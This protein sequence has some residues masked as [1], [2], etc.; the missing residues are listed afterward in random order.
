MLEI[1]LKKYKA[2]L[3]DFDGTLVN[4]DELHFQAYTK[5]LHSIGVEY[6]SFEEHVRDFVGPHSNV[7]LENILRKQGKTVEAMDELLFLKRYIFSQLLM[8]QGVK[9]IDGVIELLNKLKENNK[10]LAIVSGGNYTS[11]QKLMA[12]A[13]IP[14]YFDIII[15]KE[16]AHT[17]KPD[18]E[19]YKMAMERLSVRP[20][21]C[22]GFENDE[23]GIEALKKSGIECVGISIHDFEDQVK[24]HKNEIK[25]IKSF[26]DIKLV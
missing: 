2:F 14:S 22:I 12:F 13:G 9:P 5:A 11:I 23:L 7:V 20:N 26:K 16:A 18:P 17:P 21:D 4:T 15:S 3:F 19:C 25:V 8:K 10:K 24:R 1:D 6:V